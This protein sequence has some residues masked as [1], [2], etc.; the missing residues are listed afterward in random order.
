MRFSSPSAAKRVVDVVLDCLIVL[1]AFIGLVLALAGSRWAPLWVLISVIGM[2]GQLVQTALE[3]T[4]DWSPLGRSLV[5][6][7]TAVGATAV[8]LATSVPVRPQALGAALGA[9]ILVGSIVIEPFV[10]RSNRFKV[11]VATQLA[12]LPTRR[13]LPDLG[14]LSVATSAVATLVGLLLAVIGASSW[15]WV[16]VA[17]VAVAPVAVLA[18]DG[19]AKIVL[20]RRLRRLVPRAVAAYAPD[21]VV[22]T[23]R[24][25]DASYQVTMWLPYLER[26]GLRFVIIARNAVPA[27]ALAELT[28]VPVVEAR[29]IA[30]VDALVVPSLKAAFYV[31]ASSGNGALVRFQHL[32]HIY[33][34]HGDSD[35]PPSYNPTHAMYDQIF[36]AG[37]AATRRYAAHGIRIP[38][39]K[40]TI[41]GRPQVE[42]VKQS[43]TPIADVP[44]PTVL[45]APTWRGHVEETML[46]SLPSGEQIVSALLSRGATVIF[47]PHP[48]SY[49]FDEDAAVIERIKSLLAADRRKTGRQHLWGEA[50]EKEHSI[51][52]CINDSDA[53]V[54]DVSS[55]VSDYLF[56]GKPFAM[57]AIPAEPAAFV[58]EYPVARASYVIRADLAD[59]DA[60]LQQMLGPDP[61][62]G[63][64]ADIR[65]DYLG[66]FPADDYASAFVDAVGHVSRKSMEDMEDDQEDAAAEQ[67]SREEDDRPPEDEGGGALPG[68]SWS[69]YAQLA[70][71]VGLDLA[72]SAIALGALTVAL[73]RGPM[74]LITLLAVLSIWA[75]FQSVSSTVLT[76]SR[77]ARLLTEGDATRAVLVVALAVTARN[78]GQLSWQTAAACAILLMAIV[79]E[80][81]IRAAWGSAPP[82]RNLPD[83][84]REI[85]D[86]IP[87]GLLPIV[88]C[89][90]II[91]GFLLILAHATPMILLALGALIFLGALEITVRA[92]RRESENERGELRLRGAL[93][94]YRPEFVVYFASTV[95]ANYQVGMWLPYFVRIGRPFIIVTRTAPMLAQISKL[96]EEQDVMVPLIYRRTLRSLE[97]IIVNSM[98]AAFYVNNAARNTHL[99]ERRELRH[100]WLNHGDSE[101]P[102]CF[103]PVH[104]IYDL[105]FAA[106]QAGVDRYARHGV[107][108]PAEKFKIVGRPQVELITPARG[109][110]A[111]IEGPT[112]LYAPTWQG[113]FADTRVYSLPVGR[114]IVE[115]LL[116]HGA[117]VIFRAHPFNYRYPDAQKMISDIGAVLDADREVSGRQ[118][119][120][121]PAAEQEMSVEDCFNA[122]DAMV[123]DVS[124]VVSDYL[125]SDKPFA[126]VSVGR[127]PQ[128]L[129]VD[130]PAARAAYVIKDDLSNLSQM[131][132]DLL[133]A[134]PLAAVRNETKI[135]YLG[136]FPDENYADGFLFA[137][138]EVIDAGRR[139]PIAAAEPYEAQSTKM[140]AKSV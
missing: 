79:V 23:S 4:E 49:D 69:R 56:S 5:L 88:D 20:A 57:I 31:N 53:M 71:R 125:H 107:S 104:A 22:Y 86:F 27:T 35:K 98:T 132:D 72:G 131:C 100:V 24:P 61:L 50:A 133:G 117:R 48:F 81:R 127:T 90:V 76:P 128:Q 66:D 135:Y 87:R 136:D 94:A 17:L 38:A 78:A 44:E 73:A 55:V 124:A 39:E 93:E 101:K 12:N 3:R 7:A 89:L 83:A 111:K 97:E 65:A 8:C 14:P 96:C 9:A 25:D 28:D 95:G 1:L 15:W 138:R 62:A 103:N 134:D 130:A 75:A 112:V 108:I 119:L 92:V 115:Q 43:T 118:H 60:Q 6:R 47:R 26:A 137:A 63:R 102:A 109:P 13:P 46:Y 84:L 113:N 10:A 52:D 123:S 68:R 21:F 42:N 19:R 64:R 122:S 106:G 51:L 120:W 99:V 105:I 40:F 2:A 36:A 67:A 11:P 74:W 16:A 54:S 30:D 110:I 91:I 80:R 41:V 126:M 82:G 70:A 33:L 58:V 116:A 18:V 114:Q 45:Y 32:T 37:P 121:G 140:R 129:L 34:G 77:W 85:A 29:G 59:L 139:I